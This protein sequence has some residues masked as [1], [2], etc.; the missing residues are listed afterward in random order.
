[1]IARWNFFEK[2]NYCD[3]WVIVSGGTEGDLQFVI[4]NPIY[5]QFL[6]FQS[7]PT[8]LFLHNLQPILKSH[9]K[10]HLYLNN[11]PT[12]RI[13]KRA[14]KFHIHADIFIIPKF[15]HE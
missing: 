3:T 15:Q 13:S 6:T 11:N 10:R 12:A 14:A 5:T 2:Q 8:T 4:L 7:D 1:M 9:N